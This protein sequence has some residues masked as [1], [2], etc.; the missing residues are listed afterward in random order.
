[1][2]SQDVC[3]LVQSYLARGDKSSAPRRSPAPGRRFSENARRRS[4]WQSDVSV[5]L[6]GA[7][8]DVVQDVWAV[9]LHDWSEFCLDPNH[10]TFESWVSSIAAHLLWN[11]VRRPSRRHERPLPAD[12]A[13]VLFDHEPGPEA[14]LEQMQQHEQFHACVAQFAKR[15]SRRDG[16]ILTQRF[17]DLKTST[18]IAR[19]LGIKPDCVRKF[20]QR[21]GPELREYLRRPASEHLEGIY[22]KIKKFSGIT[23]H[24]ASSDAH[25]IIERPEVSLVSQD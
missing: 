5:R 24:S 14:E 11:Y 9:V 2:I 7:V 16:C 1:M 21:V 15:L 12:F 13:E 3:N 6:K 17:I 8:D 10:K 20:P 4:I 25:I 18:T 23:S 22:V 19:E